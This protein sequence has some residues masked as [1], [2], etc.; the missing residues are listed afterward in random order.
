MGK[1][2]WSPIL[3]GHSGEVREVTGMAYSALPECQLAK[4]F[5]S[6]AVPAAVEGNDSRSSSFFLS[7]FYK[8]ESFP[9]GRIFPNC[10]LGGRS[11]PE[12]LSGERG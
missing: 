8:T 2:G 4:V 11:Q 7:F 5:L 12:R 1:G 6:M 9:Q 10:F 3:A